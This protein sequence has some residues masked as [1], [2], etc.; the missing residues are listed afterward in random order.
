MADAGLPP[1]D[2]PLPG[3]PGLSPRTSPDEAESA[4]A[5]EV[6]RLA[7][8]HGLEA[9]CRRLVA[10]PGTTTDPG[11]PIIA[12]SIRAWESLTGRPHEPIAGLSG[13]SDANILRAAGV[14]TAR[15]GLPKVRSERLAGYGG[16]GPAGPPV[17]FQLGMNAVDVDDLV[18]LTR[19]LI[20]IAVAWCGTAAAEAPR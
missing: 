6:A 19:L 1:G 7:A 12:T 13:A 15:V 8:G 5:A 16:A 10:I 11:E 14:P 20:R 4:L 17:D 3:R 9:R 2:L 18:L